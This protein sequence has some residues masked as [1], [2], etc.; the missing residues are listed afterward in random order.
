M[1]HK[2][3]FIQDI[4]SFFNTLF[5]TK[6]EGINDADVKKR[7]LNNLEWLT[8]TSEYKI[9]ALGK[10]F[11]DRFSNF[12]RGIYTIYMERKKEIG[13]KLTEQEIIYLATVKWAENL[14]NDEKQIK[15]FTSFWMTTAQWI[16]L[17]IIGEVAK[18][19]IEMYEKQKSVIGDDYNE[20][21]DLWRECGL[22]EPIFA[23]SVCSN[24]LCKHYEFLLSSAPKLERNCPRCG[25]RWI[26][27]IL[28]K[29]NEPFSSLK[30]EGKDLSIFL[31][32]YI[33]TALSLPVNVIP[34]CY[35]TANGEDVQIDVFL[36]NPPTIFECKI[37]EDPSIT[38]YEKMLN[39][40]RE[41]CQQLISSL[42]KLGVKN[43]YIITNLK[44]SEPQLSRL[45]E[46]TEKII[47]QQELT[48]KL[49]ADTS[50]EKLLE[51]LSTELKKINEQLSSI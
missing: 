38:T 28:Y 44:L 5:V 32:G 8:K 9:S 47:G 1:T 4:G 12:T 46:E 21:V 14:Q 48:I 41:A 7:I 20:C 25:S 49:I 17:A 26:N 50:P 11:L 36:Q 37:Y 42:N 40:Y 43:G 45:K 51:K 10:E 33:K 16:L 24:E 34:E 18:G 19:L 27:I 35:V 31:S 23:I 29:V 15:R 13:N 22:I 3:H 2:N 39:I 30:L 6:I